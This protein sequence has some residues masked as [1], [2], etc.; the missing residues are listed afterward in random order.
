MKGKRILAVIYFSF[1]INAIIINA[2]GPPPPPPPGGGSGTTSGP[3]D[4][5][6]LGFVI[7]I[8]LYGQKKLKEKQAA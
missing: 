4:G 2:Q 3:I 6:A 5:G 1:F 7:A 8:A